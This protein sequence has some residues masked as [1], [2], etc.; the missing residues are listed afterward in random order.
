LEITKVSEQTGEPSVRRPVNRRENSG[1]Q[2]NPWVHPRPERVSR[3]TG[4]GADRWWSSRLRTRHHHSKHRMIHPA[5][6]KKII[7]SLIRKSLPILLRGKRPLRATHPGRI[8]RMHPAELHGMIRIL[9]ENRT[10]RNLLPNA[11]HREIMELPLL[12]EATR[13]VMHDAANFPCRNG[14]FAERFCSV[15][16]TNARTGTNVP[17]RLSLP[18]QPVQVGVGVSCPSWIWWACNSDCADDVRRASLIDCGH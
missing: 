12:A 11:Q 7:L 15:P 5:P 3:G 8:G 18:G 16:S 4:S 1:H 9:D 2:R 13:I 6:T 14:N 17:G 10:H